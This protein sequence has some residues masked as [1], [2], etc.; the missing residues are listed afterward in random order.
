MKFFLLFFRDD[1]PFYDNVSFEY[2]NIF[3]PDVWSLFENPTTC[4]KNENKLNLNTSDKTTDLNSLD[5]SKIDCSNGGDSFSSLQVHPSNSITELSSINDSKL[6]DDTSSV[7]TDHAVQESLNSQSIDGDQSMKDESFADVSQLNDLKVLE[8]RARLEAMGHKVAKNVKKADLIAKLTELITSKNDSVQSV[9]EDVS[10]LDEMEQDV[11]L[12]DKL[13][14]TVVVKVENEKMDANNQPKE[15]VNTSTTTEQQ[16]NKRKAEDDKDSSITEQT[17]KKAKKQE[18]IDKEESKDDLTT[19]R[20][21]I[22]E[23]GFIMAYGTGSTTLTVLNLYQALNHHKYDHFELQIVSELL[24]EALVGHFCS[25]IVSACYENRHLLKEQDDKK[26]EENL[27]DVPENN[28]VLLAFSYFDS[29]H[30]GYVIADDLLK[31]LSCCGINFSKRTWTHIFGNN[32]RIRYRSFKEPT[33]IYNFTLTEQP[34]KS[35]DT[36]Q[37]PS[38]KSTEIK[39]SLYV[40]DGNVFDIEKLIN[41]SDADEKL[42]V[43]LKDKL[44]LA[45]D[46]ISNLKASLNEYEVKQ[47]KM[48]SAYKKQND[49]ICDYKRDKERTKYKVIEV[50]FCC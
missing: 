13:D 31:L 16:S 38:S 39:S 37:T 14:E 41:Q 9:T 24:R 4:I 7:A 5:D 23:D 27:K 11:K 1:S 2:S 35:I 47:K 49:E 19:V 46:Q 20:Q 32:D 10:N 6:I 8:L 34:D 29:C 18:D 28:Y 3:I 40:K 50:F 45:E 15:E 44:K 43:E 36:K 21:A 42:K 12:E 48:S 33:K 22:S 26:Q 25:Y 30:C 17:T